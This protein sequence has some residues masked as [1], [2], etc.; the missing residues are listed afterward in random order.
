MFRNALPA[1]MLLLIVLACAAVFLTTSEGFESSPKTLLNDIKGKKVVV[2]LYTDN[3]GYCKQM[4]PEWE[5]ASEKASDKM[6]AVNCSD[7]DNADVQALLKKTDT[8]SFPR[9]VVMDD[10]RIVSE[11]DGPRKEDEFL[12]FV[13]TN[14]A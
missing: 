7:S 9:I 4:K 2:L 12:Q 3:C 1:Y 14:I 8:N 11:Y 10:G 5:K 13:H 6:V